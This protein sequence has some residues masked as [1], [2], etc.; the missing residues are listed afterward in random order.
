MY[1]LT[2]VL[3]RT[4]TKDLLFQ[5]AFWPM[6]NVCV[7]Q[8]VE[9][10]G[11]RQSG[12]KRNSFGEN[13]TAILSSFPCNVA[14]SCAIQGSVL[15]FLC[16]FHVAFCRRVRCRVRSRPSRV[17]C[18]EALLAFRVVRIPARMSIRFL[19]LSSILCR[20]CCSSSSST[21]IVNLPM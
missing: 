8:V 19:K 7:V 10:D 21:S 4:S 6:S 15:R 5:V 20:R 16:R 2:R 9:R 11:C 14:L 17:C 3:T 18:L 12:R 1:C 13:I